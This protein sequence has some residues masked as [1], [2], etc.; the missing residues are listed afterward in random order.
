MV[1]NDGSLTIHPFVLS[2]NLKQAL[3]DSCTVRP[4][5]VVYSVFPLRSCVCNSLLQH[6]TY[7]PPADPQI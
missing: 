7:T 6:I 4:E 2:L 1:D 3:L 5:Q